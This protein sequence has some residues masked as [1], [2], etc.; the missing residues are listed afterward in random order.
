MSISNNALSAEQIRHL[1]K[2][3]RDCEIPESHWE[4]VRQRLADEEK[5]YEEIEKRQSMSRLEMESIV[6][7]M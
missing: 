7:D 1:L 2:R 3:I 4:E 6:F 5:A